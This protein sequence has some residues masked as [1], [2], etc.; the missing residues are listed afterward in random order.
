MLFRSSILVDKAFDQFSYGKIKFSFTAT[1]FVAL[2]QNDDYY[3]FRQSDIDTAQAALDADPTN[4]DLKAALKTAQDRRSAPQRTNDMFYDAIRAASDA[5]TNVDTFDGI[6]VNVMAPFLRGAAYGTSSSV[7]EDRASGR[8]ISLQSNTYLWY[9][10][11]VSHWGRRVHEIGHSMF[12]GDIYGKDLTISTGSKYEIMGSHN[13]MSRPTGY[14]LVD[15]VGWYADANVKKLAIA[16]YPSDA[17]YEV[18]AHG[19]TQDSTSNS[20]YHVIKIDVY[21]GLTYYVEVRQQQRTSVTDLESG[22]DSLG[23]LQ[24]AIDFVKNNPNVLMFDTH[25]GSNN[26]PLPAHKSGI[27]VTKISTAAHE[28]TN[29]RQRKLTVLGPDRMLQAGEFVEDPANNLR[30]SIEALLTPNDGSAAAFPA[31]Y[32]VRVTWSSAAFVADTQGLFNLRIRQWD[33]S[34]QTNDIWFDSPENGFDTYSQP[35]EMPTGNAKKNGDRPRVDEGNRYHAH[36]WNDGIVDATNLQVTYYLISPPGVGDNGKWQPLWTRYISG[37]TAGNYT[38]VNWQGSEAPIWSPSVGEHTCAKV[39]ISKLNGEN[40]VDDNSAQENIFDFDVGGG[41]PHDA[42]LFQ[43]AVRNPRNE[44]AVL[45]LKAE[46][47]PRGWEVTFQHAYVVLGALGE[48]RV[49]ATIIND[50]GRELPLASPITTHD[51]M[52]NK[53]KLPRG[54]CCRRVSQSAQTH[55][56]LLWNWQCGDDVNGDARLR[57]AMAGGLYRAGVTCKDT[58]A[59]PRE[60]T[61]LTACCVPKKGCVEFERATDC[62]QSNG[63]LLPAGTRCQAEGRQLCMNGACCGV[64]SDKYNFGATSVTTD[65]TLRCYQ[66]DRGTCVREWHGKF[67]AG[68]SC[69]TFQCVPDRVELRLFGVTDAWDRS[70]SVSYNRDASE[71][72]AVIGGLSV[73]VAAKRKGSCW[74]VP[75]L[76]DNYPH[77]RYCVVDSLIQPIRNARV[78]VKMGICAPFYITTDES[79]CAN[80]VGSI[81][82]A[83]C[84]SPTTNTLLIEGTVVQQEGVARTECQPALFSCVGGTTSAYAQC[85]ERIDVGKEV[86]RYDEKTGECSRARCS[87]TGTP[88]VKAK[89]LDGSVVC[90]CQAPPPAPCQYDAK[91]RRCTRVDCPSDPHKA[92]VE[93]SPG[94]CECGVPVEVPCRYE[95]AT[96]KCS[97]PDCPADRSRRCVLDTATKTCGC[98]KATACEYDEKRQKCTTPRCPLNPDL[99]CMPFTHRTGKRFCRCASP[100]TRPVD[101]FS[102]VGA[103]AAATVGRAVKLNVGGGSPA[104][105]LTFDST[106]PASDAK[107]SSEEALRVFTSFRSL[108]LKFEDW[109]MTNRDAIFVKGDDESFK[110]HL[111][112]MHWKEKIA[113]SSIKILIGLKEWWPDMKMAP[114]KSFDLWWSTR[115]KESSSSSS[116][117]FKFK[118]FDRVNDLLW[119]E[120][121]DGFELPALPSSSSSSSSTRQLRVRKRQEPPASADNEVEVCCA[122]RHAKETKWAVQCVALSSSASEWHRVWQGDVEPHEV[123]V[124]CDAPHASSMPV[125]ILAHMAL[126]DTTPCEPAWVCDEQFMPKM[127]ATLPT[128]APSSTPDKPST[129]LILTPTAGGGTVGTR[130]P[131]PATPST[132]EDEFMTVGVTSMASDATLLVFDRC[133]MLMAALVLIALRAQ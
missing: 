103:Y 34:W 72:Q 119:S 89:A 27:V 60:P 116:F 57:C 73:M 80:I 42:L 15:L 131:A 96:G 76:N 32:R 29:Q 91:Q 75:R 126:K 31:R 63:V 106:L 28:D 36:V 49:L 18:R 113:Q 39:A 67:T 124:V 51:L 14:N 88:C 100:P 108:L 13:L 115:L 114:V 87:R 3:F 77:P 10:S 53:G 66:T 58:M 20:V 104:L 98:E 64:K 35:I 112:F 121:R 30:I 74:F 11:T 129:T 86:C 52:K 55:A 50:V 69:S 101:F 33:N 81:G 90:R 70:L 41:S 19:S 117:E 48:M 1:S 97:R 93:T 40:N 54:V 127:P 102:P 122:A 128:R 61:S 125:A 47:V 78:R 25:V 62:A 133:A 12:I 59:C 44:T 107:H 83:G 56:G 45:Y 37:M 17:T 26:S 120:L 5:G 38:R 2:P 82:S 110:H 65:P 109:W 123:D 22:S 95:R 92:C 105:L 118:L 68:K 4:D 7:T 84:H 79:G 71:H 132:T 99:R 130:T 46:N 24:P 8:S 85:N 9:I 111:A 16:D 43:F 23:V 94:K 21:E 6:V